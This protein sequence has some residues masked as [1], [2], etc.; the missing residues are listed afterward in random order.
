M[1]SKER[2]VVKNFLNLEDIDIEV[3]NI[4]IFIG[5]QA[6]GKSLIV[7]L[8]FY[9]KNI[10]DEAVSAGLSGAYKKEFDRG[11]EQ[12][13]RRYFPP[14]AWR[15]NSVFQVE[16]FIGKEFI[17]ISGYRKAI[18]KGKRSEFALK[19]TYSDFY[20]KSL[21]AIRTQS[22]KIKKKFVEGNFDTGDVDGTVIDNSHRI[23]QDRASKYGVEKIA[24]DQIFVPAGRSFFSYI[25]QNVF[26]IISGQG[27][28]DPFMLHLGS[29][30]E[31]F[32]GVAANIKSFQK[33]SNAELAD[34]VLKAIRKILDGE[35]VQIDGEDFLILEDGRI[36]SVSESSSGQQEFLPVAIILAT[37]PYLTDSCGR[38]IYIEEPEAHLFPKSQREIVELISLIFNNDLVRNHSEEKIQFFITTHSPYILTSFNNLIQAGSLYER[39]SEEYI[40]SLNAVIPRKYSLLSS[41]FCAY[42]VKDGTAKSI[43]D[44]ETGLIDASFIDEISEDIAVKF[45]QMID[46]EIEMEID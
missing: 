41:E 32:K 13:F 11:I 7:K 39:I 14:A 22:S 40:E 3:K 10:L 31:S 21:S 44:D 34:K 26:S 27:S 38:S 16:Y 8:L 28:I 43:I 46:I 12:R 42:H 5:S 35:Y 9:F 23:I 37:L 30:Y 6:T 36:V 19:V 1:K 20:R 2:L 15:K 29:Y 17:S 18:R 25:K 4:N 45:D 33:E 24:F